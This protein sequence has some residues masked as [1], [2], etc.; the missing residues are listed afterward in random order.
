MPHG[1]WKKLKWK[2]D[3]FFH[4]RKILEKVRLSEK[5]GKFNIASVIFAL[6]IV[7]FLPGELVNLNFVILC[8]F[9]SVQWTRTNVKNSIV[10]SL[11]SQSENNE[12][13]QH[14][15]YAVSD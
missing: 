12:C 15:G 4:D 8:P 3:E 1:T 14:C 9:E 10:E 7:F 5:M 2:F 11:K 13:N 6:L